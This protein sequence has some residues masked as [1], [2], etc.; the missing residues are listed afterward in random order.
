[1]GRWVGCEVGPGAYARL[2]WR[3]GAAGFFIAP[4]AARS[5]S[6]TR[7]HA[8]L[9]NGE[10]VRPHDPR[11][12]PRRNTL[13]LGELL[14]RLE[15]VPLAPH[16]EDAFHQRLRAYVREEGLIANVVIEIHVIMMADGARDVSPFSDMYAADFFESA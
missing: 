3:R 11:V 7:E 16:A 8:V 14:F 1:M 9:L 12:L 10:P 2:C 5:R 4:E 6:S 13:A 15:Y